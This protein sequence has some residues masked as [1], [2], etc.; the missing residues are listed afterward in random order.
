LASFFVRAACP[1]GGV[2]IDPFAGSGT[3]AVAARRH[4]RLAGGLEIHQEF[5]AEA[6]A[7]LAADELPESVGTLRV[8]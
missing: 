5:I 4:G 7:R 3:T 8:A 1:P 2:V 6:Q